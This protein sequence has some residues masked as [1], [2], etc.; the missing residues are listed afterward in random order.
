M[1]FKE[2]FSCY[3]AIVKRRIEELKFH[4]R[5]MGAE[6]KDEE[7]KPEQLTD[8]QYALIEKSVDEQIKTKGLVKWQK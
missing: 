2:V 7:P 3:N 5:L 4:A 6:I 1:T 8:G